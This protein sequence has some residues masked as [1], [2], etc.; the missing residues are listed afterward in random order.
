ML[1]RS[2]NWASLLP[3]SDV[4]INQM[5]KVAVDKFDEYDSIATNQLLA[6]E[7]KKRV[8]R[9]SFVMTLNQIN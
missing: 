7:S 3:E 5:A 9:T 2:T 1:L 4:V 8:S 6:N